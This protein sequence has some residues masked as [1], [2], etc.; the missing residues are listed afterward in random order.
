MHG[1]APR[2]RRREEEGEEGD[3][4]VIDRD[5]AASIATETLI[6]GIIAGI[7]SNVLSSDK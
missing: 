2:V 1:G 5:K 6:S 7:I 3:K 4:I